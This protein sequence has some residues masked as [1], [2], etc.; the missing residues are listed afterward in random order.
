MFILF[1]CTN[2]NRSRAGWTNKEAATIAKADEK[3]ED[4]CTSNEDEKGRGT[5]RCSG[6]KRKYVPGGVG[7]HIRDGMTSAWRLGL[8]RWMF[9]MAKTFEMEMDTVF[10][11][12]P[13]LDQYLSVHSV[14]RVSLQRLGMVCMWTVSEMDGREPILLEE[15]ALMCKLKFS[16]VQMV[17]I[18]VEF[19]RA[20][21][22]RFSPP[23]LFTLARDF[24]HELPFGDDN[25]RREKCVASVFHVLERVADDIVILNF[26]VC[27][28]AKAAVQLVAKSV[29]GLTVPQLLQDL[30]FL[31]SRKTSIAHPLNCSWR[32]LWY[33]FSIRSDFNAAS[34]NFR[35][36]R[37]LQGAD[38]ESHG[39][40]TSVTIRYEDVDDMES[41]SSS[42]IDLICTETLSLSPSQASP[43]HVRQPASTSSNLGASTTASSPARSK[44][45][46]EPSKKRQRK[47]S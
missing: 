16:R 19:V 39:G 29:Y 6:R 20:L 35:G 10:R 4:N 43:A 18:E 23:N 33:V 2:E 34:F 41:S 11:A 9:K 37:T 14:D 22:F 1:F 15:M 47:L 24:V 45:D 30:N 32:L 46:T 38:S 31:K 17:D 25:D 26:S 21:E 7:Q 3:L 12:L 27:S 13:F 42:T 5:K 28:L 8:C 44:P 40:V 36:A